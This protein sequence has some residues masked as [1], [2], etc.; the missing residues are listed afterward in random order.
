MKLEGAKL[1][2]LSSAAVAC[3]GGRGRDGS[4]RG[5]W[6]R[7]NRLTLKGKGVLRVDATERMDYA[8][9][10]LCPWRKRA[11]ALSLRVRSLRL[12]LV[13]SAASQRT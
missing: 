6:E 9:K 5:Q 3:S 13:S 12:T 10:T 4:R 1:A 8:R 11:H 2:Q 7:L